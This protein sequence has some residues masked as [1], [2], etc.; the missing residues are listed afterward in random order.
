[1]TWSQEEAAGPDTNGHG[2]VPNVPKT[3]ASKKSFDI[4]EEEDPYE[5]IEIKRAEKPAEKPAEQTKG[6]KKPN[7]ENFEREEN[8][9]QN[10]RKIEG[11][12]I[13]PEKSKAS[14][15]KAKK[16]TKN[17]TKDKNKSKKS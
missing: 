17:A 7:L 5:K 1:M 12:N 2:F 15:V 3:A 10:D 13:T 6:G 9:K 4:I 16:E 8:S 11:G 14:D